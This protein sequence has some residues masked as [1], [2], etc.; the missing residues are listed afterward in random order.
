MNATPMV[1]MKSSGMKV[2][3]VVRT[4][5]ASKLR[6]PA[7]LTATGAHRPTRAMTADLPVLAGVHERLDVALPVHHDGCVSSPGGDPVASAFRNLAKSPNAS[8]VHVL[9]RREPGTLAASDL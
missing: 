4:W 8:G 7:R 2:N 1:A 5:N 6:T 3:T 9:P